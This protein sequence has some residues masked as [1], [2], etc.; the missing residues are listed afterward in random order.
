[1]KKCGKCGR[2]KELVCFHNQKSRADGKYPN[3]KDCESK[4]ELSYRRSKSGLVAN[5][6]SNQISN[7][8]SRKMPKPNYTL[9]EFKKWVFS[10]NNFDSLYK[11]WV[12]SGFNRR[13]VPSCDRLDN[14]LS[15]TLDNIE[16]VSF[17]ENEKR[18]W[19][20]L[21]SGSFVQR[22][23]EKVFRISDGK[24]VEE[25]D[26]RALAVKKYGHT[27]DYHIYNKKRDFIKESEV[28]R[29]THLFS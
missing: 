7:S 9:S 13:K 11:D 6:Y 15:Y 17:Y 16:L 12:N 5:I 4:R 3:C 2:V 25:F 14:R 29:L 8:N 10:Q 1:M 19:D 20:S 28:A 18:H 21:V 26:S 27:V 24:I 22:N 23:S